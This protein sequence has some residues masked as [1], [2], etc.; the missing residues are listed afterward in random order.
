MFDFSCRSAASLRQDGLLDRNVA[1][2]RASARA[3]SPPL[4]ALPFAL[5]C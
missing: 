1:P 2:Y 3:P 4:P 5:S